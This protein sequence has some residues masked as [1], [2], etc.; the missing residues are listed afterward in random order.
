MACS[1]GPQPGPDRDIDEGPDEADLARFGSETIPCP[2]CGSQ[3][4]DEAEWCHKCGHVMTEAAAAK[5]TPSW[6]F[7]TVAGLIAAFA[8]YL[9]F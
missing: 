6:V 2:A 3:V 4:Y 1:C 8:L 5:G 7:L 9:V